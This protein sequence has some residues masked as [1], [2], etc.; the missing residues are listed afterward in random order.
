MWTGGE[1]NSSHDVIYRTK[2]YEFHNDDVLSAWKIQQITS[3]TGLVKFIFW[4]HPVLG[5]VVKE[6]IFVLGRKVLLHIKFCIFTFPLIYFHKATTG[7]R[8]LWLVQYSILQCDWQQNISKC[9]SIC[10]IWRQLFCILLTIWLH[11]ISVRISFH[12]LLWTYWELLFMCKT[13]SWI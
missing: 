11:R 2:I 5:T 4:L 8:K 10:R 6:V 3:R 9:L 7:W 12:Y 13:A 1:R